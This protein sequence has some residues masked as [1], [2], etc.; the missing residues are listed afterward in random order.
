MRL[1]ADCSDQGT[2]PRAAAS[3]APTVSVDPPLIGSDWISPEPEWASSAAVAEWAQEQ[4]QQ[5][6]EYW[7]AD[8]KGVRWQSMFL[9]WPCFGLF[10]I[11]RSWPFVVLVIAVNF[12]SWR[13][14]RRAELR[15]P[16]KPRFD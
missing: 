13:R 2:P 5:E 3:T 6:L 1:C 7:K 12:I 11:F 8:V 9:I 4:Y 16:V 10:L 14:I 15:R